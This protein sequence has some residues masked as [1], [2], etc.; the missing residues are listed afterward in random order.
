MADQSF[1]TT[2]EFNGSEYDATIEG[3]HQPFESSASDY[4]GC[5]ESFEVSNIWIRPKGF[6]EDIDLMSDTYSWAL[7][8]DFLSALEDEFLEDFNS[9]D[10]T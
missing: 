1:T 9:Y 6:T 5:D 8:N 3:Y 10:P 4:P 7:D 2:I